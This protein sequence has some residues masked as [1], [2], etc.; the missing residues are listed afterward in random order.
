MR[1]FYSGY[2]SNFRT[3]GQHKA[4][5]A[6]HCVNIITFLLLIF[7]STFSATAQ[8]PADQLIEIRGAKNSTEQYSGATYGPI[9]SDDTLWRIADRYRQNKNL[10]IYQVMVAIYELNKD[11]F[12]TDNLNTL[13]N[14]AMLRLPSERYIARIDAQN[15]KIKSEQDDDAWS[16][17]SQPGQ[18]LV[19]LKPPVKLVN[20]DDLAETKTE[21]ESRLNRINEE[22]Q[23]Q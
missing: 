16:P 21:I 5:N 2:K 8:L 6:R 17:E 3:G 14:G 18:S 23:A 20:R 4:R 22:Q 19:N 9:D 12:A 7:S 15:A 1:I 13:K 10:S 11:A